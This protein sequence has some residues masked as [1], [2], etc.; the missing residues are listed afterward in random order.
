MIF[1][2]L[3]FKNKVEVT[4]ESEEVVVCRVYEK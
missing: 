1:I 2:L 3:L 4:L